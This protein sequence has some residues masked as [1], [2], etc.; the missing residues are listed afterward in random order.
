MPGFMA[1][2]ERLDALASIARILDLDK[3]AD[4]AGKACDAWKDEIEAEEAYLALV[5]ESFPPEKKALER[6]LDKYGETRYG[7]AAR[8]A[9]K[10]SRK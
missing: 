5:E 9:F 4:E 6:F 8:S 7:R 10:E 1:A 2:R 3:A